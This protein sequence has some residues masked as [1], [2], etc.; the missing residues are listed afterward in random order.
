[1]RPVGALLDLLIISSRLS[2]L[3][4]S[5]L[6]WLCLVPVKYFSENKNFPEMLFSGKENIFKC[7]V[8]L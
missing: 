3:L 7:L 8:S 5:S 4:A 2:T 6:L 1:M